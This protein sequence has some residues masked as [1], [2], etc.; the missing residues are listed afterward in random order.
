MS[1]PKGE[2]LVPRVFVIM[3]PASAMPSNQQIE[4]AVMP[5]LAGVNSALLL[6]DS[7]NG[8]PPRPDKRK[9]R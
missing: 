2:T 8:A 9:R 5:L 4:D 7:Q 6:S 3:A 1:K